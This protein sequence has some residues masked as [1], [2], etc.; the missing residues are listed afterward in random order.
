MLETAL[1]LRFEESLTDANDRTVWL[2]DVIDVFHQIANTSPDK[3]NELEE[4]GR[5]LCTQLQTSSHSFSNGMIEFK[6][7]K[8]TEKAYCLELEEK[9][10][11]V[12]KSW[13]KNILEKLG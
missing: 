12:K 9:F 1:P 4:G 6:C 10:I 3:K 11:W 13:S 8:V 7:L 5:Y 2:S